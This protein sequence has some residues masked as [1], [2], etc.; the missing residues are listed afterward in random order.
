MKITIV[1]DNIRSAWNVGSI[2]RTCDALGTDLILV[3]YTPQPIGANLKLLKK[4]SIGAENTV[5]WTHFNNFQ[6]VFANFP[7]SQH[8]HLAIDIT[9]SSL[10]LID[11]LLKTKNQKNVIQNPTLIFLWFGNEIHGLQSQI[12]QQCHKTL[13]LPM[14]GM[15]ESLNVANSVTATGYLFS[16][17]LQG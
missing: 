9:P 10:S 7:N 14:K 4:T 13:H 8:L 11:F 5:V 12:L 2:F 3:G 17:F 6:Q 1:L 15:K 16:Y